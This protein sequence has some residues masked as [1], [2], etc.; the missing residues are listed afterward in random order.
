MTPNPTTDARQKKIAAD[1]ADFLR[2]LRITFDGPDGSLI[3]RWLHAAAGTRKPCFLPGDRDPNA[4]AFRDGRHSLV[5][6]IEAN[7]ETA[8]AEAGL[9]PDPATAK[10][11]VTRSRSRKQKP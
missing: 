4:A 1:R 5:W 6:E 11:P 3:L 8:R 7:L 9:A 10:P 2:A